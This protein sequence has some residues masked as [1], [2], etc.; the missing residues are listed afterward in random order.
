M[1]VVVD[2]RRGLIQRGRDLAKGGLLPKANFAAAAAAACAFCFVAQFI[3]IIIIWSRTFF[4][5][6]GLFE[7]KKEKTQRLAM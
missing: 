4:A 2:K 5:N 6:G 7:K 3:I 1:G